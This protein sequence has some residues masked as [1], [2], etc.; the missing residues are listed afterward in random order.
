VS[1]LKILGDVN[2]VLGGKVS[3]SSLQRDILKQVRFGLGAASFSDCAC[4]GE[5]VILNQRGYSTYVNKENRLELDQGEQ[6]L[7]SPFIMGLEPECQPSSLFHIQCPQGI[8]L[9][10]L[11][12]DLGDEVPAYAFVGSVLFKELFCSYLK[13]PPIFSEP[14]NENVEKYWAKTE[15]LHQ[16]HTYVFGVVIKEKGKESLDPDLLKKAF[17]INPLDKGQ[18]NFL[19]H[20]HAALI[21][22][23]LD[24]ADQK[25]NIEFYKKFDPRQVEGCRHLFNQS[26][27]QEGVLAFFELREIQ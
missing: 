14:I 24:F 15:E 2:T 19:S 7:R 22:K 6:G 27:V 4:V 9:S 12:Q 11:F 20:T 26:T 10:Q 18:G 17:Y 23:P 21:E 16:C 13:K 3:E 5:T 8:A 25:A 1:V